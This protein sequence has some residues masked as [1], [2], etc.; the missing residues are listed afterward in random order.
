MCDRTIP[1]VM[2]AFRVAVAS[3]PHCPSRPSRLRCHHCLRCLR[4]FAAAIASS[5][6][7]T[8][9][10]SS[11][12]R[13]CADGRSS[14]GDFDK[15]VIYYMTAAEIRS[16]YAVIPLGMSTWVEMLEGFNYDYASSPP[17]YG[18]WILTG[19]K[20]NY[21]GRNFPLQIWVD[22]TPNAVFEVITNR[23]TGMMHK[24]TGQYYPGGYA[25]ENPNL[26]ADIYDGSVQVVRGNNSKSLNNSGIQRTSQKEL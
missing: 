19:Q 8:A 5:V 24:L 22:A 15:Y 14:G 12:Q 10:R 7:P 3:P 16:F 1:A 9:K 26:P 18:M 4:H 25:S 21:E 20:A 17:A 2:N 13:R 23:S 6:R 11:D